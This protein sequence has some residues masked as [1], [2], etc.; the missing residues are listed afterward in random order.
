MSCLELP[1]PLSATV[2]ILYAIFMGVGVSQLVTYQPLITTPQLA[3]STA[4]IPLVQR[5]ELAMSW[6]V[7]EKTTSPSLPTNSNRS[8]AVVCGF[9]MS[10]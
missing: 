5:D 6:V 10:A 1:F 8:V 3:M 9:L 7:L 2:I 4:K